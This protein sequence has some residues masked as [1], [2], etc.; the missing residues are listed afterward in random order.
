V[1]TVQKNGEYRPFVMWQPQTGG[2]LQ[3]MAGNC[4][5]V[6]QRTGENNLPVSDWLKNKYFPISFPH[7]T[8]PSSVVFRECPEGAREFP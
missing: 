8:R 4:L 7:S 3:K 6:H 5:F 1:G 2:R